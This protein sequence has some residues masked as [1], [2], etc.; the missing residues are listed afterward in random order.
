VPRL[1]K[2]DIHPDPD[3]GL[4]HMF[5]LGIDP[6]LSITGY[7]LVEGSHPPRG[8]RAGVIRTDTDLPTTQRLAELYIGLTEV[9]TEAKPD[10]IALE[11]VFTNRNLQTA[12][13]VSRASGV[14]LLAAAEAGLEVFEYVPTA[15]K[16]AVTGDGS[17]N[18]D[19]VQQMVTRL[20]HLKDKPKP[21]DAADALAIALCHLRAA[22]LEASR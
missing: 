17:A 18:K 4:E 19:Q 22:P 3:Y 8:H 6:G 21:A 1:N 20:L 14:A 16:S 11:T 5:V 13:S 10:V 7:G 9:I 2:P 15:I 12:I